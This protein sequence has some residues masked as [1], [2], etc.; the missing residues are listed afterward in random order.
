MNTI[1]DL[2]LEA[3]EMK[4]LC[5]SL[6]GLVAFTGAAA[7]ADLSRPAPQNYYKAPIAAPVYNWTGLYFGINGGGAFGSSSWDL[8]GS[9]DISGGVVGGT[10]GYNWQAGAAV[11]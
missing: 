11:F 6:I 7:A 5:L 1:P 2:V 3:L 4:R 10:V 8:T 9:R